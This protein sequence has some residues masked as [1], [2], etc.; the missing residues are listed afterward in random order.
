[1]IDICVG[2]KVTIVLSNWP[3][4]VHKYVTRVDPGGG[5]VVDHEMNEHRDNEGVEWIRGHHAGNSDDVRACLAARALV[6][7]DAV[8]HHRD[9]DELT[10]LE[11]Q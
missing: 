4:V 1:M 11:R 2:D 8:P 7:E 5:F 3:L 6:R 9:P 10:W